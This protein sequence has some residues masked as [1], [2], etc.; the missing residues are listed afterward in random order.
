MWKLA[1]QQFM[2]SPTK[3]LPGETMKH[4]AVFSSPILSIISLS[5]GYWI[6][7]LRALCVSVDESPRALVTQ[8]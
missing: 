8:I 1:I 3:L 5:I 2:I 4:E 6:S 7:T